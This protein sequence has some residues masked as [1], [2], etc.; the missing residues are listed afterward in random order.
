[1]VYNYH[2]SVRRDVHALYY[3]HLHCLRGTVNVYKLQVSHCLFIPW[4]QW[5]GKYKWYVYRM[6]IITMTFS[7]VHKLLLRSIRS[8]WAHQKSPR[9]IQSVSNTPRMAQWV[10]HTTKTSGI[11]HTTREV[12]SQKLTNLSLVNIF[13]PIGQE[14]SGDNHRVLWVYLVQ[15][16][17]KALSDTDRASDP[18]IRE[19]NTTIRVKTNTLLH[20]IIR[21]PAFKHF[22]SLLLYLVCV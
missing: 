11:S 2:L 12:S 21:Q 5:C 7:K 9:R 1:M 10:P 20:L 8:I 18:I 15:L 22:T 3:S 16:Y 4:S 13:Q 14:A 17:L 19:E 6:P